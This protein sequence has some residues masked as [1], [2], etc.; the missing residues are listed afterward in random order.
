MAGFTEA[1]GEI[2]KNRKEA[3]TERKKEEISQSDLSMPEDPS[4][5]SSTPTAP[6]R[7]FDLPQELHDAI[8]E[9]AYTEPNFKF[10]LI[11]YLKAKQKRE[12]KLTGV[13]EESPPHKVNEWMVSKEYF[14]IAAKAWV[15]AQTTPEAVRNKLTRIEFE[16]SPLPFGLFPPMSYGHGTYAGLFVE[17]GRS[18]VIILGDL[19]YTTNYTSQCPQKS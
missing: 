11:H 9:L 17:F 8:F 14:R 1:Q 2:Q 16:R 18:F 13:S 6:F 15:E 7:L 5:G 12:Q 10:G 3:V 4:E 19:C